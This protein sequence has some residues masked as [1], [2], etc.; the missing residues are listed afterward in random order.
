MGYDP[1]KRVQ[2][3]REIDD[4]IQQ[5][6]HDQEIKREDMEFFKH[7]YRK[8]YVERDNQERSENQRPI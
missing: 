3:L 2:S 6:T 5:L 8:G 7:K 1:Q 4:A